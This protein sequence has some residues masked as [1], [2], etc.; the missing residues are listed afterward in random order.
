[1]NQDRDPREGLGGTVKGMAPWEDGPDKRGSG[2]DRGSG[3][4]SPSEE[5]VWGP[6]RPPCSMDQPLRLALYAGGGKGVGVSLPL[7]P[8][9]GAP[10]AG[11]QDCRWLR[12]VGGTQGQVWRSGPAGAAGRSVNPPRVL[13]ADRPP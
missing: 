6:G 2:E 8:R 9:A 10:G 1:M 5:A 13:L 12:R 11:S 3:L 4:R 7:P